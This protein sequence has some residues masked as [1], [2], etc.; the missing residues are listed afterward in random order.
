MALI[1]CDTSF[2][3]SVYGKDGFT[4]QAEIELRRLR[5][6]LSISVLNEFELENS[7][8]LA[9]FRKVMSASQA[10]SIFTDFATDLRVGKLGLAT[11]N[12]TMVLT[13]A[14]RLAITHTLMG[15][16]RAFDILHVAAALHLGAS[17]FLSF[18]ANQRKLA[19][20]EGLKIRPI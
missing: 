6:V 18:D 16:H 11:C 7:V 15:G 14:K 8:R 2:L 5:S 13:E 19:K 12:L 17:E 20:A 10:N 4:R 1:C 9:V 3:I